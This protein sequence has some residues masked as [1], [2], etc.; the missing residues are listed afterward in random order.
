V[1]NAL[2]QGP[3]HS[4]LSAGIQPRLLAKLN[5]A[6]AVFSNILTLFLTDCLLI[7]AAA[8]NATARVTVSCQKHLI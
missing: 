7:I 3:Q 5:K 6:A 2:D 1:S 8:D 4:F